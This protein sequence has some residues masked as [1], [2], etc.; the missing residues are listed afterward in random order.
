MVGLAGLGKTEWILLI[1]I[2]SPPIRWSKVKLALMNPAKFGA[3]MLQLGLKS[4]PAGEMYQRWRQLRAR[5]LAQAG[6]CFG[7]T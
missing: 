3:Q 7:V 5:T 2:L 1:I 4:S 6:C